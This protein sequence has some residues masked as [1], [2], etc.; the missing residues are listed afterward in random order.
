MRSVS[1]PVTVTG[2]ATNVFEYTGKNRAGEPVRGKFRG[3]DPGGDL[4]ELA[5]LVGWQELSVTDLAGVQVGG[6]LLVGD[7]LVPW[8][9]F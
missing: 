6:I 9:G 8:C 3:D 7:S 2:M 5:H 1:C 4:I